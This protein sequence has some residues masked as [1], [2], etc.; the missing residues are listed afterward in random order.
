[1]N[2][3]DTAVA[4]KRRFIQKITVIGSRCEIRTYTIAEIAGTA[5]L[6]TG[7]ATVTTK[8]LL[9]AVTRQSTFI[10]RLIEGVVTVGGTMLLDFLRDSRRVLAD[11]FSDLTKGQG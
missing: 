11:S 8:V 9:L 7:R 6:L 4:Y 3:F 2:L 10:G 5:V 1:M